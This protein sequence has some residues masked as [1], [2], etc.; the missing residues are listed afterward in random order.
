MGLQY[1]ELE[2]EALLADNFLRV[3]AAVALQLFW[4]VYQGPIACLAAKRKDKVG[5]ESE[6][7]SWCQNAPYSKG[8]PSLVRLVSTPPYLGKR[9]MCVLAAGMRKAG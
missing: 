8:T 1:V 6:L 2:P 4:K 5:T 3:P 9:G 7:V